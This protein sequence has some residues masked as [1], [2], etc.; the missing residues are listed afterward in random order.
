MKFDLSTAI[1]FLLHGTFEAPDSK[2]VHMSRS[3]ECYEL[4]YVTSGILYISDG[5]KQ[6]VV[7][8]GE[9]V[10]TPPCKNQYGW[11]PS[12]CKFYYFHFDV[13]KT[14]FKDAIDSFFPVCGKY[15]N[16]NTIEKYYTL[17]SFEHCSLEILNHFMAII[18]L[19]LKN[20]E[21]SEKVRETAQ[22]CKSVLTYIQLAP[23]E[24]LK[25]SLV[26][27]KFQYNEK[28]ISSCITKE[29]GTPLK[30]H[31]KA[32]L[33]KRAKHMLEYTDYSVSQIS[34]ML[35]YSDAHS[36][37][38]VFKNTEQISPKAYRIMKTKLQAGL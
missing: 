4:F 26:A 25:V 34:E 32:E 14:C 19:E 29:T 10:I 6:Y 24:Q 33:I 15:R 21:D 31:L 18:L 2:W 3:M 8:T 38:H 36:F 16:I 27:E 22:L 28:Y 35:G 5:Q 17:L 7:N 11:K 20:G 1:E 30:K 9:F 23:A 13:K 12:A 37:S